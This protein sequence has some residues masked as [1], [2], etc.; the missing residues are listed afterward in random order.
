MNVPHKM[1]V[2]LILGV[3]FIA[4]PF[5]MRA[6]A[7]PTYPASQA[8]LHVSEHAIIVGTLSKVEVFPK[9]GDILL[10]INGVWP[11]QQFFALIHAE[12]VSVFPDLRPFIGHALGFRGIILKGPSGDIKMHLQRFDQIIVPKP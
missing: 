11:D 4:A 6:A 2:L 7:I 12:H 8:G 9:T 10:H 3:I 1:R 5:S